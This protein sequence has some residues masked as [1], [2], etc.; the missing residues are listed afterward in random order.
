MHVLVQSLFT[1]NA[2]KQQKYVKNQ[3]YHRY[4]QTRY[5]IIYQQR[6]QTTDQ[7]QFD[8]AVLIYKSI[9]K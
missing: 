1:R 3:C 8:T 6:R 9:R 4:T 5:K 7:I 2:K